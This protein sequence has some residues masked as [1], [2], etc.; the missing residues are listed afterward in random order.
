LP[1]PHT[2]QV[3]SESNGK[4]HEWTAWAEVLEPGA[5]T[6][7]L[8]R[9]ADQFYATRAAAITR[10][11][12]AGSVTYIGVETSSGD[13]EKEIVRGVFT[14]NGVA[15]EN[16]P[17][18]VF[19]DWRDGFWIAS[20]FSSVTILAPAPPGVKLLVGT[21]TLQPAGVAIWKE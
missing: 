16:Y 1:P 8:A 3:K 6:R 18:Q 4:S 17:D 14:A 7:V 13:L 9:H 10:R 20:N 21:S 12:G 5:G 19:V 15:I 2:G 11:L